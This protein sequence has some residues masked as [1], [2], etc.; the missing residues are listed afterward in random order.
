MRCRQRREPALGRADAR[1][2]RRPDRGERPLQRRL[3]PV[4]EALDPARLEVDAADRRGFDRE[5]G[6]LQPLQQLLPFMLR[7]RRILLDERE[8]R[9]ERERLPQPH[10]RLHAGGLGGRGHRPEQG[11]LPGSRPERSRPKRERRPL[12]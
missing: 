12:P 1:V 6:V 11:L 3:E 9:A 10:P 7:S 4:V 5:A 2:P 8:V